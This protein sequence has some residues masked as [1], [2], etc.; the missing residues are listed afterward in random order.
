MQEENNEDLGP[1]V[2]WADL[3]FKAM[4]FAER[5][6]GRN[7]AWQVIGPILG[8][9]LAI[10]GVIWFASHDIWV[11]VS[12]ST[13]AQY[14]SAPFT[15]L[16]PS[17]VAVITGLALFL[18]FPLNWCVRLYAVLKTPHKHSRGRHPLMSR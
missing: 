13:D 9:A 3:W 2:D 15:V 12:K 16:L 8:L 18:A 6:A 11:P 17:V 10:G 14:G 5:I 1:L 4:Y 7:R